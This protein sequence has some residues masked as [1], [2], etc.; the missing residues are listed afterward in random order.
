MFKKC[1]D[2]AL[3]TWFSMHCGVGLTV[4]FD[5]RGPFQA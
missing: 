1:G 3:G 5:L 2:M 4:G